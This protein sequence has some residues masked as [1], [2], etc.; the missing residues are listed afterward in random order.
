M[1]KMSLRRPPRP[2]KLCSSWQCDCGQINHD[3]SS[4][5]SM[6]GASKP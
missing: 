5:C 4:R 3:N 2:V 1:K 6:C